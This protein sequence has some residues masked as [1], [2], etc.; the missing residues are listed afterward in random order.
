MSRGIA[1]PAEQDPFLWLESQSEET[2]LWL[3]EQDSRARTYLDGLP[4]RPLFANRLER[5]LRGERRGVPIGA[6]GRWFCATNPG[7]LQ[8]DVWMFGNTLR[9][10]D[11]VLL[12]PNEFSSDGSIAVSMV[13]P[14]H[15]GLWVAYGTSANG[16][17]CVTLRVRDVDKGSDREDRVGQVRFGG[18]CWCPDSSG[19]FYSAFP[20]HTAE[21]GDAALLDHALY[22][23]RLGTLQSDDIRV[24]SPPSRN[25]YVMATC[26]CT[27]RYLVASVMDSPS[28]NALY[29]LD[30]CGGNLE[31]IKDCWLTIAPL[32][33]ATRQ[34]VGTHDDQIVLFVDDETDRGKVVAAPCASPDKDHW[35]TIIP[36]ADVVMCDAVM[37]ADHIA[38][39]VLDRVCPSLRLF[40][41]TGVLQRVIHPPSIGA[42]TGLS[43]QAAGPEI[44]YSFSAPSQSP[45]IRAYNTVTHNLE[46]I[47]A[48][49]ASGH[50]APVVVER[51]VV[52]T[53]DGCQIP[54]IICRRSDVAL[55]GQAATIL[56]AYGGF[57][58]LVFTGF[59]AEASAWVDSG[60][61]Y[62]IAC[63][64][65]GGELG[66]QWHRAAVGATKTRSFED[67]VAAAQLL[68]ERRYC[69]ATTLLANGGSNGGLVVAAAMLR[70][71]E[72]F[73]A[74]I[75]ESA[76][77]DML[78]FHRFTCGP[79]W[80]DEYGCPDTPETREVLRAFS[81]LHN[82]LHGT[83][84]PAVL[85]TVGSGDDRVVPC[86][87]AKF[88]ATLIAASVTVSEPRPVLLRVGR[89][90]HIYR[91]TD[92]RL[93][94]S[95]DILAFA[96]THGHLR[97]ERV[98]A[99]GA[100]G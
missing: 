92:A 27:G 12:D 94:E 46:L 73:A 8:Q 22:Y 28:G 40:T 29:L 85:L 60:G 84:Y 1:G 16:S 49:P 37:T 41:T 55:D 32:P 63:I 21:S 6:G 38:L 26:D 72:L 71:P 87:S 58:A 98:E 31:A 36:E 47:W 44:V 23:H 7:D 69:S 75:A 99:E 4:A 91:P 57:G 67:Y 100:V 43:A 14:S 13:T 86:H 65:G 82:V 15:D 88:A 11:H 93:S 96:A 34:L 62:A 35:R 50:L 53:D 51:V 59:R 83:R 24:F 66:R 33:D 74:V 19:F 9:S 70:H 20:A 10:I 76:V 5:L 48:S 78:R 77:L 97:P 30:L 61:I 25:A 64:R 79:A 89:G 39:L 18:P 3:S 17:D 54:M 68:I 80:I 2:T 95:A 45:V 56:Y 52:E 90:G 81:P 42:I